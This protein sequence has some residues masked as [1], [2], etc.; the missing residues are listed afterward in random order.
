MRVLFSLV[1]LFATAQAL[2]SPLHIKR[3]GSDVCSNLECSVSFTNPVTGKPV[4][5]GGMSEPIPLYSSFASTQSAFCLLVD[6]CACLSGVSSL[7]ESNSALVEAVSVFGS[8]KV[9]EYISEEVSRLLFFTSPH[10]ILS[11]QS[12]PS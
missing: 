1:A 7:L 12:S 5:F 2:S 11:V 6:Q 3:G 10:I 4:D 9:T 8:L